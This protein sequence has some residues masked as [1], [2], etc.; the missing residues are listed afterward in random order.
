MIYRFN[1]YRK[2]R[3]VYEDILD[4]LRQVERSIDFSEV[5]EVLQDKPYTLSKVNNI[6]EAY[7]KAIVAT[8]S[9]EK[10]CREMIDEIETK[11]AEIKML[12]SKIKNME[13]WIYDT[14]IKFTD[15]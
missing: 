2:F 9:L 3:Y 11:N 10:L 6:N 15:S 1:F 13:Q 12:E 14:K 7:K 8:E 4:P 5:F